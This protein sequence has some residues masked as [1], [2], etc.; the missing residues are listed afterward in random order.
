[1][2]EVDEALARAYASARAGEHAAR[3]APH[4]PWSVHIPDQARPFRLPRIRNRPSPDHRWN[5][6]GQ[7]S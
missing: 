3:R 5:C 1:M 2:R 4:S 6:S 7:Q